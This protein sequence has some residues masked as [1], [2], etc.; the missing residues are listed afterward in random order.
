MNYEPV[1]L[2]YRNTM[3]VPTVVV[4]YDIGHHD[5]IKHYG[6][7][8]NVNGSNY[9]S[10]LFYLS[11]NEVYDFLSKHSDTGNFENLEIE[12]DMDCYYSIN[13]LGSSDWVYSV[14]FDDVFIKQIKERQGKCIVVRTSLKQNDQILP[15]LKQH[16]ETMMIFSEKICRVSS[17]TID[18]LLSIE[19]ADPEL[20]K[21][22]YDF[23]REETKR[24]KVVYE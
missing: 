16:S 21:L 24:K 10:I 2:Y 20:A 9:N 17:C 3:G 13:T 11:P 8:K 6:N 15:F 18:E 14:Y 1:K 12:T 19:K 4:Q 7:P 23:F 5:F 22:V